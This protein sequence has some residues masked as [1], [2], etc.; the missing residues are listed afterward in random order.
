M[1]LF[2]RGYCKLCNKEHF[3]QE[4][5]TWSSENV[6]IDKI[7]QEYQ[8]NHRC[9]LQW[10]PYN[11]FRNIKHIANG[12][13]GP[14][15]SAILKNGIKE[16]WNFNKLDWEYHSVGER[17][18]LKK[19]SEFLKRWK[20]KI[21]LLCK[22]SIGLDN[23]HIKNLVHRDLNSG[24]ILTNLGLC[25]L[26]NDLIIKSDNKSNNICGSIPYIP[27]EVLRGIFI[28]LVEL[29]MKWLLENNHFMIADI[30]LD[31]I[32]RYYSNLMYKCWND[33]NVLQPFKIADENQE[34]VIEYQKQQLFSSAMSHSKSC[35][36]SRNPNLLKSNEPAT[37]SVI[38]YDIDSKE[39]QECIDWEKEIQ[40]H[41]CQKMIIL[42]FRL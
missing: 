34:K 20:T 15:Y 12:V 31:W 30:M 6:E 17:V 38:T 37:S 24:N 16:H 1:V 8:I 5:E 9:K 26:E 21:E 35:Y 28:V 13:Y 33:D 3:I 40:N 23:L 32:P 41:P 25:S 11:N 7:I 27:S 22:I 18:A 10:I 2:S 42:N 14:V 19:I 36:I 39:L 29:C 4:F